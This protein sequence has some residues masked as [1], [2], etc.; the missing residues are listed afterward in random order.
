MN[1]ILEIKIERPIFFKNLF[2]SFSKI[3]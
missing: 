3:K 1:E 2:K